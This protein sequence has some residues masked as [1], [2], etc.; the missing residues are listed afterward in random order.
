MK[1]AIIIP[2]KNARPYIR[3]TLSAIFS[4]QTT[5]AYEVLLI[6]SGS[7]DG[8][9]EICA[10]FPVR[11]LQIEPSSFNHGGTRNLGAMETDC[12]ND[13]ENEFI[14]YL[15][16]DAAP[17][18]DHW[19]QMLLSPFLEDRRIAGVFSRHIPRPGA[20]PAVVRQLTTM[21]Q[22]GGEQR[23]VKKMPVSFD[24]Y[25]TQKDYYAFFSN[26]SSALRRSVWQKIPFDPVDFAEDARWADKV[27]RAGFTIVYEPASRITHSHNYNT[28]EQ[29]RQNVDHA[30]AM[31]RLFQPAA[32]QSR[33][34]WVKLFAGIPLQV[35]R[36][37][38]FAWRHPFFSGYSNAG[39]IRLLL[40]S[41]P[42][43][44][45]T[46]LGA[47]VGAKIMRMPTWLKHHVSRQERLR[48]Q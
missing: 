4:Q 8:T 29:F 31:N 12:G 11:T 13:P 42:W 36:D 16:Q 23:L 45:A 1:A 30:H 17:F 20:S 39:K 34:Y 10:D 28:L 9:L 19:L 33:R 46:V 38:V 41:L 32:Y 18:D 15:S 48:T 22:S 6:D 37:S 25:L 21:T 2:T 24:E 14:V 3:E 43:Q 47:W 7:K 5:A 35:Y 26:T 44:T 40:S 27:L